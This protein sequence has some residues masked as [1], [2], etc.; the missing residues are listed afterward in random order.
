MM[1]FTSKGP[2]PG[3]PL[4]RVDS[5]AAK[6]V[7]EPSFVSARMKVNYPDGVNGEPVF[8]IVEEVTEAMHGL[9]KQCMIVKVLGRNVPILVLSRKLRELWKPKGAMY[10]TNLP[11]QFFMVRFEVEEEYL[12]ALTGGP[13]KA[14]GS[15]L[16]V[17]AWSP[18]FEPSRDD[19]TT[20]PV[21]VRFS[22]LPVALYHQTIL[23]GLAQAL[24]KPL[25]VDANTLNFE[26]PR[27]ARVC[28]EVDLSQP[29]KRSFMVNGERYFVFYEG[30][31]SICSGCEIFGHMV[32]AC[33]KVKPVAESV[34]AQGSPVGPNKASPSLPVRDGFTMVRRENRRAGSST[35]TVISV[36]GSKGETLERNQREISGNKGNGTILVSNSFAGLVEKGVQP[37]ATKVISSEGGNK[38]NEI[39]GVSQ[40]TEKNIFKVIKGK[41]ERGA[42]EIVELSMSGK[43]L[44]ME[45][46][47]VGR[48]GGNAE[49]SNV[50]LA[51]SRVGG[52]ESVT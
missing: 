18:H 48:R 23:L 28:V 47:V 24:G 14:F 36:P 40:N 1:D 20:I 17:R 2:P 29:L 21:W 4:D 5:W 45:G 10:V 7:L 31:T 6:E 8:T 27:F 3:D 46:N 26:R 15:Y 30:L 19:I 44:R 11:R 35:R 12:T 13:W 37:Q 25:R 52:Q 51:E 32:H 38:E 16:M 49:L 33:P 50:E 34:G 42:R 39:I 41:F 43:R 9:W 22:N